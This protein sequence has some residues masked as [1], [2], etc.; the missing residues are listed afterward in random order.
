MSRVDRRWDATRDHAFVQAFRQ[1]LDQNDSRYRRTEM[2]PCLFQAGFWLTLVTVLAVNS[3]DAGAIIPIAIIMSL[4]LLVA[5]M[6][7][8]AATAPNTE[9]ILRAGKDPRLYGILA[10]YA[11]NDDPAL[12]RVAL[13][14]LGRV[15][16]R[17]RPEYGELLE[18]TEVDALSQLLVVGEKTLIL[19]QLKAIE[20]TRDVRFLPAVRTLAAEAG[21]S[22]RS[23][24]VQE[25]A[26]RCA[27]TLERSA[28][29]VRQ[30]GLLL[31]AAGPAPDGDLLRP[32]ATASE[33]SSSLLHTL[34][35]E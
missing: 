4:A 26:A 5:W 19:A 28:E 6:V 11:L 14:N 12:Q 29:A 16:D 17:V 32:A 27:A 1:Q 30:A 31:R 18:P 15:L 25:T 13:R 33:P 24:L 8:C 23:R 21:Q 2:M 22:R 3:H 7:K 10:Y 35:R 34:D 20:R 9:M